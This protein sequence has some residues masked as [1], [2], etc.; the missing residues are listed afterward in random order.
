VQC[1]VEVAWSRRI[2]SDGDRKIH[3]GKRNVGVAREIVENELEQ[4]CAQM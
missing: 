2:F 3:R 4:V 1:S